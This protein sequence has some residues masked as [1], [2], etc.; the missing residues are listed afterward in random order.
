MAIKI[1][2]GLLAKDFHKQNNSSDIMILGLDV[3]IGQSHI[4]YFYVNSRWDSMDSN[5]PFFILFYD[6]K[7]HRDNF[8]YVT[9][10]LEGPVS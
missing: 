6:T 10:L 2:G 8:H 5:F 9:V 1:A 4:I 3:N 7:W